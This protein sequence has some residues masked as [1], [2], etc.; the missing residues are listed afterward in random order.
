M[1]YGQGDYR[2]VRRIL[3]LGVDRLPQT[4]QT[5]IWGHPW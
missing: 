2:T 4:T 1:Y 5:D 3:K